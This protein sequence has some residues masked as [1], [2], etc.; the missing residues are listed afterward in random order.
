MGNFT[1]FLNIFVKLT[2]QGLNNQSQNFSNVTQNRGKSGENH[3]ISK[4]IFVKKVFKKNMVRFSQ[5]S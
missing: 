5:I 1:N 3:T 2:L 4:S